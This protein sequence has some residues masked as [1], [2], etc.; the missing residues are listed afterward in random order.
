MSDLEGIF[1]CVVAISLVL[2]GLISMVNDI[3]WK[4]SLGV[5]GL[6]VLI[7]IT[8]V[9]AIQYVVQQHLLQG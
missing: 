6:T 7:T 2:W 9:R 1:W 8:I 3:G 4:L 5:L